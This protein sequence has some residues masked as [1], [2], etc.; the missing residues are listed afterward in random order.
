MIMLNDLGNPV[1]D[2]N[3]QQFIEQNQNNIS[4]PIE[5]KNLQSEKINPQFTPPTQAVLRKKTDKIL[6]FGIVLVLISIFLVVI[7]LVNF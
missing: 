1:V 3:N 4:N 5:D 6:W 2:Q 7:K